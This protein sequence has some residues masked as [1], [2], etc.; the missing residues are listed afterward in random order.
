MV[1]NIKRLATGLLAGAVMLLIGLL[2]SQ[3]FTMLFP[4]LR[5]EYNNTQL[6][7][8]W[9]D[10][11]MLLYFTQPFVNGVILAWLW[12]RS[13]QAL[14]NKTTLQKM[15]AFSAAYCVFSLPGMMMSLASFNVSLI[16]VL[17]W[18]AAIF[19]ESLG[20]GFIFSRFLRPGPE[21]QP[22]KTN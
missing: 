11:L 20:A 19:I 15:M 16:M 2:I 17:S 3:V 12:D 9:E 21:W 18:S 7:R 13:W 1:S 22:G 10:P 5:E 14:I 8:S 6:F 4:A